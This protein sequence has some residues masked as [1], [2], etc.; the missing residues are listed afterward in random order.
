VL[1]KQTKITTAYAGSYE[2]LEVGIYLFTDA[3]MRDGMNPDWV[4]PWENLPVV[5]FDM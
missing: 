1:K 3:I 4:I 5:L 2:V